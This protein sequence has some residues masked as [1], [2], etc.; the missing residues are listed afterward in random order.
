MDPN[1][2]G[3]CVTS[4]LKVMLM[5]LHSKHCDGLKDKVSVVIDPTPMRGVIAKTRIQKGGVILVP[6][7]PNVQYM[8]RKAKVTGAAVDLCAVSD[9]GE[10]DL[11]FVAYPVFKKGDA[12]IL[13]PFWYVESTSDPDKANCTL[14]T[15]SIT[16]PG[17]HWHSGEYDICVV[18]NS[19][20]IGEGVRLAFFRPHGTQKYPSLNTVLDGAKRIR[21]H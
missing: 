5:E 11:K 16:I 6:V 14:T 12:G 18:T 20:A 9:D 17:D 13:A 2:I 15:T 7:T 21:I 3:E 1:W 8:K 19:K 4:Q 10:V